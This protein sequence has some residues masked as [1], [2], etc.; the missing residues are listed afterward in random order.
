ML[1]KVLQETQIHLVSQVLPQQLAKQLRAC[2]SK[3][4]YANSV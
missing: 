3:H 4:C 1:I 2:E